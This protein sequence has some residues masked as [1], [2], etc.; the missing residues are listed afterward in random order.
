[1]VPFCQRYSYFW[2]MVYPLHH[3]PT[4]WRSFSLTTQLHRYL[5]AI[6]FIFRFI[7]HCITLVVS[8]QCLQNVVLLVHF[9]SGLILMV[10]SFIMGLIRATS[11]VN[12]VLK[13]CWV[14][15]IL[16]FTIHFLLQASVPSVFA[17]FLSYLP[18]SDICSTVFTQIKPVILFEHL[19]HLLKI[20]VNVHFFIFT[21]LIVEGRLL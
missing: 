18:M 20:E 16:S 13:V 9:L 8:F 1:M 11:E 15:W 10:I 3:Q 19:V 14:L 17:F 21:P 2:S 5:S 6:Y 4:A 7:F 12:S